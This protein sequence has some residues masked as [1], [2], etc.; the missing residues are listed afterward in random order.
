[1]AILV[2]EVG[3]RFCRPTHFPSRGGFCTGAP[4]QGMEP[5][6]LRG[7]IV[8]EHITASFPEEVRT[9]EEWAT[10]P[11]D[12]LQLVCSQVGLVP[13]GSKHEMALRFVFFFPFG[14]RGRR[15]RPG[16]ST[17][18]GN[19]STW[20]PSGGHAAPVA[21]VPAVPLPV[22]HPV[23]PPF[24]FT[25]LHA[26]RL[27]PV[28]PAD[29]PLLCYTWVYVDLRLSFGARSLSPPP[30]S[31]LR[32]SRR[33]FTGLPYTFA[34]AATPSITS[35][36]IFWRGPPMLRA[37]ATCQ[38]SRTSAAASVSPS[39]RRSWSCRHA[40]SSSWASPWAP[41][42]RRC[43]S[44]RIN[45]HGFAIACPRGGRGRMHQAGAAV[46]D[47]SAFLRVQG[48]PSGPPFPPAAY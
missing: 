41:L 6:A 20:S 24:Q 44:L 1:M 16:T 21:S 47:R 3:R 46:A 4:T 48:G 25:R 43:A 38:L 12:V 19:D 17:A 9:Y 27:C 35:M 8:P 40:A 23:I 26:F 32:S 11:V 18:G 33:R 22:A 45:L 42:F 34:G 29:W 13:A 2:L 5:R 39:R 28:R 10:Y 30:P 7:R 31:F 14:G 37:P 36:I 15:R